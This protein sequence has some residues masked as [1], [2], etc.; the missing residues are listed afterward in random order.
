MARLDPNAREPWALDPK[1][2]TWVREDDTGHID[3]A[4]FEAGLVCNGPAC[5]KCFFAFCMHCGF[6]WAREEGCPG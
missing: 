6:N 3:V 5:T 2:H 1:G 4:A